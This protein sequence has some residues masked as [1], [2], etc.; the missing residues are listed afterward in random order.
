MAKA[1]GATTAG[2]FSRGSSFTTALAS[3]SVVNHDNKALGYRQSR[4]PSA[5]EFRY[6][7]QDLRPMHGPMPMVSTLEQEIDALIERTNVSKEELRSVLSLKESRAEREQISG[8]TDTI[9]SQETDGSLSDSDS[10][11]GSGKWSSRRESLASVAV[12]PPPRA[13]GTDST[14]PSAAGCGWSELKQEGAVRV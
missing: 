14:F 12:L 7:C 2:S 5:G 3:R 4:L 13:R 10:V 9:E 1:I 8:E 11:A 6:S